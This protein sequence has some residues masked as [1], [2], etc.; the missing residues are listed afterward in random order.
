MTARRS[1]LLC[2][3][4]VAIAAVAGPAAATA[5]EVGGFGARP[6]PTRH[7]S[8]QRPG[9]YF[10]LRLHVQ[11][12]LRRQVIVSNSGAHTVR[13][14]VDAVDGTTGQT[15]GSVYVNRG[16]APARAGRWV[17]PDARHL[18]LAPH[19]SRR[20]TFSVYVP[21]G[22]SPGNHLAGLAF[23]DVQA[24]QGR[25]RF[26][27][28]Q[29]VRVVVGIEL[30]VPGRAPT[31]FALPHLGIQALGGTAMPAVVVRTQNAGRVLC[32]P[33]LA[34]T[35]SRPGGVARTVH[36]RLDTV[37]PGDTI[38][39]PL[40]WP[41]R[42]ADG[43][44]TVDAVAS[45]CGP[46]AVQHAVVRLGTSLQGT[47][48]RPGVLLPSPRAATPSPA[49]PTPWWIFAMIALAGALAGLAGGRVRRRVAV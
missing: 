3:L 12:R 7:P 31:R 46:H 24:R 22:A 32:R 36:R 18:T 42:L 5:A 34:V 38:N 21:F 27:I 1:L 9:P 48:S 26:A 37:L 15:S 45:G 40:P 25:G 17:R 4:T 41:R 49:G 43:A 47:A 30:T 8:H 19:T 2:L 11:H 6:A 33:R 29:V 13:L 20:L 39:Y 44:Y 10:D 35:L 16:S 14:L 23:Q 28:R